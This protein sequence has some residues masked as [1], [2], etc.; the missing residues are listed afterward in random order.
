MHNECGD[1]SRLVTLHRSGLGFP[2]DICLDLPLPRGSLAGY[3]RKKKENDLKKNQIQKESSKQSHYFK[4]KNIA[5]KL[6]FIFEYYQRKGRV[7]KAIKDHHL[8]EYEII[9][10]DSGLDFYRNS[11]QAKRWKAAGKKIIL[12][13]YGSDLRIRGIIREMEELADISITAE[14]DHLGLKP[15]LEFIFYPYDSSELPARKAKEDEVIRIVHSPTNRRF[16]GTDLIIDVIRDLQKIRKF[17]FVLLENRPRHEVLEVKSGCDIG[18][19]C[20]GNYLGITGYGKSALEML[21]LGI[22]VVTSMPDEY[23]K[24]LPENPFVVANTKEDLFDQL[25]DMIDNPGLIRERGEASCSWVANYHGFDNVNRML[26]D[27]YRKYG[28]I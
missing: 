20:I 1:S 27:L 26:Y 16:K 28:L 7:E 21:A 17:E 9:Y 12:C 6:Y 18:I 10:Y 4:P 23:S 8:D 11:K 3:W 24:W 15:D 2:E 19:G 25:L 14:Y 22:P 5:E 13:Y